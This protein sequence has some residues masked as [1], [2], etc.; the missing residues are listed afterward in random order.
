MKLYCKHAAAVCYEIINSKTIKTQPDKKAMNHTRLYKLF[1]HKPSNQFRHLPIPPGKSLE[2]TVRILSIENPYP[3]HNVSRHRIIREN[4][5]EI[6]LLQERERYYLPEDPPISMSLKVETDKILVKCNNCDQVTNRLC[7]HQS[8]AFDFGDNL[9]IISDYI[10]YPISYDFILDSFADKLGINKSAIQT[11]Y[12]LYMERDNKF[13]LSA[14][15]DEIFN[16]RNEYQ[17]DE[18]IDKVDTLES[19]ATEEKIKNIESLAKNV[20]ALMWNSDHEIILLKGKKNKRNPETISH[21]KMDIR[22]GFF[23]NNQKEFYYRIEELLYTDPAKVFTHLNSSLEELRSIKHF[24]NVDP[25]RYINNNI[26]KSDLI[27][28]T[29]SEQPAELICNLS[30][31]EGLD[32]VQVLIK[33]KDILLA[34]SQIQFKNKYFLIHDNT[35]YIYQHECCLRGSFDLC[36]FGYFEIYPPKQKV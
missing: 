23:T 28:F 29:I 15:S 35:G 21:I 7:V 34:P 19:E 26:R 25:D 5:L 9:K 10:Q 12:D 36:L 33:I 1:G 18:F 4:E 24:W 14:N 2:E 6:I 30:S 31:D 3:T 17:I 22:P 16:K 11:Y 27:P 13:S 8:K 32:T 20:N